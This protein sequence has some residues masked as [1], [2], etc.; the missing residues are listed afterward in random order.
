MEPISVTQFTSFF[1]LQKLPL[2]DF[3]F[4]ISGIFAKYIYLIVNNKL[5]WNQF[6]QLCM[7]WSLSPM[8]AIFYCII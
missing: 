1:H 8:I 7:I 3:L 4:S 5:N 6:F 2:Y